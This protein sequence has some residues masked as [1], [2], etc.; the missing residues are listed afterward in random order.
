VT[1][2][3][4]SITMPLLEEMKA[5]GLKVVYTGVKMF[6]H[7][8]LADG[9]KSYRLCQAGLRM[10]IPFITKCKIPIS[11][12]DLQMLLQRHGELLDFDEFEPAM[13]QAITEAPLGTLVCM[14]DRPQQSVAEYVLIHCKDYC[15]LTGCSPIWICLQEIDFERRPLAWPQLGQPHGLENRRGGHYGRHEGS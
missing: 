1:Y 8:N 9:T 12:R 2:V 10:A 15:F 13:A 5:K 6:E 14:L 4:K 3:T 11:T 7:S